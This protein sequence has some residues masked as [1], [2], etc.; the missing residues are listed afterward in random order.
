MKCD[1]I[2]AL[3]VDVDGLTRTLGARDSIDSHLRSCDAC[4]RWCESDARVFALI[5]RV[6][7]EVPPDGFT[8]R[9]MREVNA[10]AV[11]RLPNVERAPSRSRQRPAA[12]W[13]ALHASLA[14]GAVA[15]LLAAGGIAATDLDYSLTPTLSVAPPIS[16]SVPTYA[17]MA[18]SVD[19]L[20]DALTTNTSLAAVLVSALLLILI[21]AAAGRT[22][23]AGPMLRALFWLAFVGTWSLCGSEA[24]AAVFQEPSSG[25]PSPEF[26]QSLRET[27]DAE[28]LGLIVLLSLG[29]GV[30]L[31]AVALL[32][33]TYSP[34]VI[35]SV[36][37]VVRERSGAY[38]LFIGACDSVLLFVLVVASA[39]V[40]PLK[41][42]SLLLVVLVFFLLAFGFA[43]RARAVGRDVLALG[44]AVRP[45]LTQ[46]VVGSS[47]LV[48]VL[49]VP[50]V[51]QLLWLVLLAQCLG[52]TFL[53]L[54]RRNS[55]KVRVDV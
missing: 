55:R 28:R 54:L 12:A 33:R 20:L 29:G 48:A 41:P 1:D 26:F 18:G 25:S 19:T 34:K 23:A 2:R 51:G 40:G 44:G 11:S 36:D 7:R 16:V 21:N 32:L 8:T 35:A 50:L 13:F 5:D 15:M 37:H 49:L 4:S 9:V 47:V 10:L 42:L 52:T 45:E 22:D 46:T 3:L 14:L 39:R 24:S 43:A 27:A 17:D 53:G 38:Q 6:E 31:A 30:G